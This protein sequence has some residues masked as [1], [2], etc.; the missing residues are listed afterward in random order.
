MVL[1]TAC[2]TAWS[3]RLCPYVW[4]IPTREASAVSLKDVLGA[5]G[6]GMKTPQAWEVGGLG[7]RVKRGHSFLRH[8]MPDPKE[9]C[10]L[11]PGRPGMG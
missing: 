11:L 10:G 4:V 5:R 7:F 8:Y 2:P 1:S 6:E 3:P 9:G